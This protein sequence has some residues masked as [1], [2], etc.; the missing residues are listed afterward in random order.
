MQDRIRESALSL[1]YLEARPVTGQPFEA[2]R[3]R[4]NSLPLGQYMKFE[5]DPAKVTGWSRDEITIWVALAPTPPREE[6]PPDRGEMAAH[7]LTVTADAKR[8]EA[9]KQAVTAMGYEVAKDSPLPERAAAVRAGLGVGGL[10]GLLLNPVYGSFTSISVIVIHAPPPAN[11]RG[12]EQDTVT[13]CEQCGKCIAVCPTQAISAD[14][15][16][17]A[18]RCLCNS[19]YRPEYMPEADYALM[20]K[21]IQ[22]CDTCQKICPYNSHLEQQPLPLD[23]LQSMTLA[24]LLSEPDLEGIRQHNNHHLSL[25]R[26]KTQAVLAAANTNRKDLLP[27]IAPLKESDDQSLA[28]IAT[29]AAKRLA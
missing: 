21:R 5:H 17:D 16:I 28:T 27:L 26:L 18:L 22:G 19:I 24:A 9:W 11:A 23:I 1:G 25:N 7:Y 14:N 8:R 29:W 6:W 2:W 12:Q 10:N 15:G 4:L 20:G 13:L 3:E